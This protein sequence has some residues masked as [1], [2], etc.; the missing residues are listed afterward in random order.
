M[1]APRVSHIFIPLTPSF[2]Y[3]DLSANRFSGVM[4]DEFL[5]NSVRVDESVYVGLQNN[6]IEG[7]IPKK[8]ERFDSLTLEL[9]GNSIVS[10]PKELCRKHN[11]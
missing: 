4:T 3:L 2:R 5:K 11:W 8:L 6:R 9:G 1:G 7:S 10:I